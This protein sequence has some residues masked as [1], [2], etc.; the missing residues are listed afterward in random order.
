MKNKI[1]I[2]KEEGKKKEE[3]LVEGEVVEAVQVEREG[4][5]G[6]V[7]KE[8]I[9]KEQTDSKLVVREM[10]EREIEQISIQE[11]N[12]LNEIM[13]ILAPCVKCGMCK[14]L[15]P[16]FSVLKEEHFS[17]R[18]HSIL[19]QE[20]VIDEIVFKCNM[21]R[22]CE[23]KCP[24]N[25]KICDAIINARKILVLREKGI[26]QNKEMIKNVKKSGNPFGDNPKGDKL[27]CC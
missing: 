2:N 18:G 22:A 26:E 14:S 3:E 7:I 12:A 23:E 1:E 4:V 16:V 21:C 9:K 5:K 27:Y 17:P 24:L 19:L 13:E 11:K 15:C 20:K 6:E 8:M 25:I 10:S